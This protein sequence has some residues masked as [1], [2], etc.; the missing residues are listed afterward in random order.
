M[1]L[2]RFKYGSLSIIFHTLIIVLYLIFDY[3][4][5]Q[6]QTSISEISIVSHHEDSYK[7]PKD[8][9]S[10]KKNLQENHLKKNPQNFDK[11]EVFQNFKIK[12]TVSKQISILYPNSS[13]QFSDK[14]LT[15]QIEEQIHSLPELSKSDL[16]AGSFKM[17][18]SGAIYKIGTNDNPHPIYPSV[19]RKMGWEGKLIL[20]VSIDKFGDVYNL[21]LIESSGYDVLDNISIATLKKWKF[22]PAN[23][24]GFAVNDKLKIPIKFVLEN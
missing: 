12:Q 5:Y 2:K 24:N 13:N 4:P 8:D 15:N 1:N 11:I 14:S 10:K 3:S 6:A 19:A 22:K 20:E 18:R 16:L 7:I 9:F 21:N 23:L 17:S